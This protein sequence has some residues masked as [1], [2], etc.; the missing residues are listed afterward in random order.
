MA[1]IANYFEQAQLSL[2]A[3]ALGLQ[4]G[5]FGSQTSEYVAALVDAGM[6]QKQAEVFADTYAVV[7]QFTDSLTGFSG[8]VFS[9]NGVNYFA[10]RGTEG[11]SFSGA[12]D[13][14]ANIA[15]VGA[16][17]IA[18]R[19]G[20]ALFNWLQRLY[21]APGS[22]VAQY[23]YNSTF[24]MMTGST[25]TASGLLYGQVSPVTVTGDS[26]GGHL[27]MIMSR[28]VPN[29]VSSVY[30]YNAPGFDTPLGAALFPLTSEGFFEALMAATNFPITGP[31]GTSWNSALM[32]HLFVDGDIVHT[33]GTVPGGQ[34]RVFSERENQGPVDAHNNEAYTDALAVYSL[35]ALS[36]PTLTP[37]AHLTA[38]DHSVA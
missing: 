13:W 38:V 24:R 8:T 11:F 22:T 15:D 17:G 2:A 37:L 36:D 5:A 14:L 20:L 34:L 31:I 18:I 6:S 32:A 4:R 26:L 29:L 35:F 12:I 19:Q 7:D 30:T 16:D 9:K 1:T 27:A 21:A 3:Y 25:T 10:I 33:I 23:S 28:L